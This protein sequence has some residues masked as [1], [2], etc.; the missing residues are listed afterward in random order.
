MEEAETPK[1][2]EAEQE[3]EPEQTQA[4]ETEAANAA[5]GA[6]PEPEM[7]P[8]FPIPPPTLEFLILSLRS[9]AEMQLGLLHFGEEKDR[10]KPNLPL[11]RHTIDLLAMLADKTKGNL[12]LDEQRMMENSLTELR[13]RFVQASEGADK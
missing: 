6:E 7:P 1:A 11:A 12:S 8:D 9:Q 3:Q 4:P 2:E 13:F 10:P 5:L